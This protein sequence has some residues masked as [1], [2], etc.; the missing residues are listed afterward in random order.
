MGIGVI[1]QFIKAQEM[2]VGKGEMVCIT[3]QLDKVCQP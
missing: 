2:C 3:E 1:L